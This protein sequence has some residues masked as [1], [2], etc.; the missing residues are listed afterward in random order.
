MARLNE[1]PDEIG[2]EG[3][4]RRRVARRRGERKAKPVRPE[5]LGA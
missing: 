2:G 5:W 3:F 1:R 4:S